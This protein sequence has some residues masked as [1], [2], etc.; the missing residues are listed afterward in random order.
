MPFGKGKREALRLNEK[1][2]EPHL[3]A[4]QK[5]YSLLLLTRCC[6]L[7]PWSNWPNVLLRALAPNTRAKTKAFTL[8]SIQLSYYYA[9]VPPPSFSSFLPRARKGKSCGY[10]EKKKGEKGIDE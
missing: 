1:G 7:V 10:S 2:N 4:E 8:G 5:L 9:W 6:V 3:C